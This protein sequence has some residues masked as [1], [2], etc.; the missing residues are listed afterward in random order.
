MSLSLLP[1][2]CDMRLVLRSALVASSVLAASASMPAHAQS[3]RPKPAAEAA[4]TVP[5]EP[6]LTTATYGDWVLR[7]QRLAGDNAGRICEVS[8]TIQAQGQP[9]P[10]AQIAIGRLPGQDGLRMT[11]LLPANVSFPSSVR[12]AEVKDAKNGLDL[13]WRRCNPGACVADGAA[14]EAVLGGWRKTED[15][16]R[17]AFKDADGRE[18][19]VSLSLRGLGPALDALAKEKI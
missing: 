16:A 4:P 6:G 2:S 5:A 19:A 10:V 9:A 8:Q 1:S 3:P 11:V 17:I 18:V 12:V 14:T 15:A 7:C 13:A